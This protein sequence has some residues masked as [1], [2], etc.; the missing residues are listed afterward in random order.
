MPEGLV[1]VL[2]GLAVLVVLVYMMSGGGSSVVVDPST[3]AKGEGDGPSAQ[4]RL[5]RIAAARDESMEGR[6]GERGLGK[7]MTGKTPVASLPDPYLVTQAS[8]P[9]AHDLQI[10]EK[11]LEGS[12]NDVE[13]INILAYHYYQGRRLDDALD[14]YDRG[15]KIKPNDMTMLFYQGNCFYLKGWV[16][17]AKQ[18]WEQ[19]VK[20]DPRS[21]LGLKAL[22]RMQKA[23]SPTRGE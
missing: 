10:M 23:D 2:G 19:V 9:S 12:P 8:V 3:K 4:E 21:K 13:L 14:L 17:Q 22:E 20:L 1:V 6:V 11:I 5:D 7:R 18:V 15:L 16:P